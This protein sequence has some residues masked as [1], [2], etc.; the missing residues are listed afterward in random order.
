MIKTTTIIILTVF[1]SNILYAKTKS[2]N[3]MILDAIDKIPIFSKINIKTK[4]TSEFD[5][6]DGKILIINFEMKKKY[7]NEMK[8]FYENFFKNT[9]WVLVNKNNNLIYFEKKVKHTQ[10]KLLIRRLSNNLWYLNL[11]VENF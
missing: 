2:S 10:K 8:I 11:I 5:S 1:F 6:K 9:N 3:L 7:E 4:D